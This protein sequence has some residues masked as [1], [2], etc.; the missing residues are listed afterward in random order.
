MAKRISHFITFLIFFS[1]SSS[2]LARELKEDSATQ[3][4][5]LLTANW[6]TVFN[7]PCTKNWQEKW[8]LDGKLATVKNT[9]KG[10]EFAAGPTA[11]NDAHHAVLWTKQDFKGDLKIEYEYTRTDKEIR[12]VNIL[13]I[14]ATGSGKPGFATNIAAWKQKRVIP[15]MK[16]YFQN[17]HTYHISYA[18]FSTKNQTPGEDYIRARRYMCR[19]L[20]GTELDNEYKNTGFF[21]QGIPH[22][23]TIIKNDRK[24]Y[25][26]VKNDTKEKLYHFK[27]SKFPPILEGK[28]GIR[29]MYTRGARYKNFKVS[30]IGENNP[31]SK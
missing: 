13:Y 23:I 22:K 6:Q 18:A 9:E 28:I 31:E 8:S 25:M 17:M 10:M 7:N 12:M 27:N 20:K 5:Q 19:E 21:K 2:L 29:H 16:T 11:F 1:I 4:D 24:I 26:H 3:F 15:S 14:Q 30:V